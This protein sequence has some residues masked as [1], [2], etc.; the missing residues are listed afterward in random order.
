MC[1]SE[2]AVAQVALADDGITVVAPVEADSVSAR[3]T[4]FSR[5]LADALMT[6]FVVDEKP[7]ELV[8]K[9]MTT[10]S[11]QEYSMSLT[12]LTTLR[13]ASVD[14]ASNE[15]EMS[16]NSHHASTGLTNLTLL[17]K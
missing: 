16:S 3:E 10:R 2:A 1:S 12:S 14:Q 4:T 5:P 15:M 9:F 17:E 7:S 13:S 11:D 6:G 8:N